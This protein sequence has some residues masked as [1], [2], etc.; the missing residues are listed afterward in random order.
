[1]ASLED[2]QLFVRQRTKVWNLPNPAV[3]KD[4]S[5]KVP[6]DIYPTPDDGIAVDPAATRSGYE[7]EDERR[8]ERLAVAEEQVLDIQS[9]ELLD[10]IPTEEGEVHVESHAESP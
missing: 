10:R 4:D 5:H 8:H 6:F 3:Q 2:S 9:P 7:D 1:M